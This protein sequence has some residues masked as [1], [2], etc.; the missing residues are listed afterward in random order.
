MH[1]HANY[2]SNLGD[3]IRALTHCLNLIK[4]HDIDIEFDPIGLNG[5]DTGPRLKELMELIDD[6]NVKRIKLDYSKPKRIFQYAELTDD[7][8]YP[9][10][11]VLQTIAWTES[12]PY[13]IRWQPG[14]YNRIAYQFDGNWNAFEKNSTKEEV[15]EFLQ[16][17]EKTGIEAVRLGNHLTLKQCAEIAAQSDFFVGVCSGM[18]QLCY[19]VGVPVYII[20]NNQG[21]KSLKHWHRFKPKRIYHTLKSF[22]RFGPLKTDKTH[23]TIIYAIAKNE[24]KFVDTFMLY[25][26]EADEVII[27]DTGST[28][29]TVELFK[30]W[31]ATVHETTFKPWSTLSEYDALIAAGDKP[32]RFDTAR[33][34]SLNL[35]P[36]DAEICVCI[37][38]DEVLPLNWRTKVE[39]AWVQGINRLRYI[40]AWKMDSDNK[41]EIFF[42]YSKI[43]S[44]HDFTWE[45]PAHEYL[46][47]K[48]GVKEQVVYVSDL[49]IR[50]YPDNSKQ[51]SFYKHLL[52]LGVRDYPN[53]ERAA[54]YYGRELTFTGEPE[55]GI[56]E[57][58]R[59]LSLPTA[60]W[61]DERAKAAK[62]IA[63]TYSSMGNTTDVIPWLLRSIAE[64]PDIRDNWVALAEKYYELNDYLGSYYA[65]RQ[66]LKIK[67]CLPSHATHMGCWN[68]YPH[69]IAAVCAYNLG[70]ISQAKAHIANALRHKPG[71]KELLAKKVLMEKTPESPEHEIVLHKV[72]KSC[73]STSIIERVT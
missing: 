70:L 29:R 54:Y 19:S 62:F 48:K 35:V 39:D 23:K 21:L 34:M 50:H 59:Y 72:N 22:V 68:H 7:D 36:E 65:V 4:Q 17:C 58:K 25:A 9:K 46:F 10:G 1:L 38:I 14:K 71:D 55:K 13:T 49:M 5:F 44:R 37:D 53:S 64:K 61:P 51:R 12:T 20:R 67:K 57:L 66:A 43:H 31:G 52:E 41:P 63:A 11:N 2:S 16:F 56:A 69:E 27:L 6:P 40:Y 30:K 3:S 24:E 32:F 18:A 73:L 15:A 42:T 45:Y 8:F 33:N 47:V 60:V 26:Q 28:D